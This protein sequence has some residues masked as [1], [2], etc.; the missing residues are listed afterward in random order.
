MR[1]IQLEIN[2]LGIC[3][4]KLQLRCRARKIGGRGRE[5][6]NSRETL[7]FEKSH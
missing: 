7:S 3:R 5:R 6:E 2:G 4:V 1:V